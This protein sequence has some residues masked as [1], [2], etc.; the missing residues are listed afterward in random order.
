MMLL[1]VFCAAS[2]CRLTWLMGL[3]VSGLLPS[4]NSICSLLGRFHTYL[5]SLPAQ[6]FACLLYCLLLQV[7]LS[8]G[9]SYEWVAAS[10]PAHREIQ[11]CLQGPRQYCNGWTAYAM[12][13]PVCC[14]ACCC[15]S[16]WL[17]GLLTSGLRPSWQS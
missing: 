13:M 8:H 6:L 17:M 15:R 4:C 11:A 10:L 2:C 1:P 14:I 9:S 3:L 5:A 12:A 7:E 16:T